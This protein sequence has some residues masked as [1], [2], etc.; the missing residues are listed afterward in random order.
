MAYTKEQAQKIVNA[1]IA[2]VQSYI[3]DI[4]DMIIADGCYNE[5][6]QELL[7]DFIMEREVWASQFK[8]YDPSFLLLICT[9]RRCGENVEN[10]KIL[11]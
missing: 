2:R 9:G 5:I 7:K 8:S 1:E 4:I 10:K 6:T 11:A 3:D